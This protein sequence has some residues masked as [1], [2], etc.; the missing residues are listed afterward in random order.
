MWDKRIKHT[1]IGFRITVNREQCN[2]LIWRARKIKGVLTVVWHGLPPE[3]KH[4]NHERVKQ[5]GIKK[6]RITDIF[7]LRLYKNEKIFVYIWPLGLV[8]LRPCS[9]ING[10]KCIPKITS[11]STTSNIFLNINFK[12]CEISTLS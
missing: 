12:T 6:K 4:I 8:M 7:D 9:K 5:T 2:S 10:K 1:F 11:Q 3:S